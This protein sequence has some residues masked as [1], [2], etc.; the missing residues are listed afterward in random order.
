MLFNFKADV[1]CKQLGFLSSKTFSIV[2]LP[3]GAKNFTL[4]DVDCTGKEYK[5]EQCLYSNEECKSAFGIQL[6]CN[7]YDFPTPTPTTT[8]TLPS[9]T[10]T[11]PITTDNDW[12][13]LSREVGK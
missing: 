5:L 3:D 6:T 7:R 2:P 10:T 8:P 1:V 11:P 13:S 12:D 9:T 4:T